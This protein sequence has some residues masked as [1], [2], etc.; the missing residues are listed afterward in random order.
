MVDWSNVIIP[1]LASELLAENGFS[2]ILASIK[3]DTIK[4]MAII[5]IKITTLNLEIRLYS[6]LKGLVATLYVLYW[7]VL[8]FVFIYLPCVYPNY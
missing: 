2:K 5:V 3:I 7:I 8:A 4:P 6:S 1:L